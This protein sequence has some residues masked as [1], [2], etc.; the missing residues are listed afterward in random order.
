M[1]LAAAQ[2]VTPLTLRQLVD[3]SHGVVHAVVSREQSRWVE[4]FGGRRIVTWWRLEVTDLIARTWD[5][6]ARVAT[7]GGDVGEVQQW[8]PHEAELRSGDN[9]LLFLRSGVLGA[10][11]VT[12]MAQGAFPVRRE[13]ATWTVRNS[14]GQEEFVR[15]AGSACAA[16]EGRA[17][18]QVRRAI[19]S[20]SSS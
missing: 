17:L 10:H 9:Y 20:L 15:R 5:P 19:T 4:V 2:T 7:L 1:P 8:V 14:R 18:Y 12:G 6:E 11:W 16:L 13:N 3:A